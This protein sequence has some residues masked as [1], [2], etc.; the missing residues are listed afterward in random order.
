MSQSAKA[1]VSSRPGASMPF[2]RAALLL[3]HETLYRDSKNM[4]H[5]ASNYVVGIIV[6]HDT[7][8][9]SRG[10]RLSSGDHALLMLAYPRKDNGS[11]EWAAGLRAGSYARRTDKGEGILES[12]KVAVRAHAGSLGGGGDGGAQSETWR[13]LREHCCSRRAGKLARARRVAHTREA[14]AG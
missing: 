5:E 13:V 6:R 2:Y 3:H 10:R 9:G 7:A 11:A 1:R 8:I 12:R 4:Y 14:Q